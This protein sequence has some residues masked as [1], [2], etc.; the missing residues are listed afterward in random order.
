MFSAEDIFHTALEQYGS[1]PKVHSAFLRRLA[2]SEPRAFLKFA[3][4]ALLER[5]FTR[6]L[7]VVGNLLASPAFLGHLLDLH[8]ES[9][10]DAIALATKLLVCEP[11]LDSDLLSHAEKSRAAGLAVS[12]N[13]LPA[14]DIVD[15]IS[16]DARLVPRM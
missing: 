10:E 15:A 6:G 1:S 4:E 2:A 8:A 7:E 12:K 13:V 11:R 5:D 9:R 3:R 16:V 14:I